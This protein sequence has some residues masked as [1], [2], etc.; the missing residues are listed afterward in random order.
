MAIRSKQFSKS[1]FL[2][3][4]FKKIVQHSLKVIYRF[5]HKYMNNFAFPQKN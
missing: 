1:V 5:T 4:I 2:K 3:A